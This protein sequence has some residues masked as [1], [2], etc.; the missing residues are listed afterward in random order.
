MPTVLTNLPD[1][2][3]AL[4]ATGAGLFTAEAARAQGIDRY[5]LG[6]WLMPGF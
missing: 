1:V 5:R 3:V 4:L 6:S 2:V